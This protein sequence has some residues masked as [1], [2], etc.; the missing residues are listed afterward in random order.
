MG[1]ISLVFYFLVIIPSAI[2]HE[3]AHGWMADRLGDPTARLA[4]RLTIDPRVHIDP[5]GT[6]AMPLVLGLLSGGRFLFAYAKP[7]PFNPYNLRYHKWGPAMVGI[8]GPLANF[9]LALVFALLIRV[10]P[11][12]N[13]SQLLAVVVQANLV[14]MV[15]NL[16]P[17]PPLD[18][19]KILYA[20]LPDSM[21]HIK[22]FLDRYG[23]MLLMVFIFFLSN[24]ISPIINWLF[25][26]LLN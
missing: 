25:N 10:L 23:F 8:A 22:I 24:L 12:T 3:Y 19:S 7:V 2:I 9:M 1:I 4:G 16:V 14:L 13:F 18:G 5:I 6:I 26:L 21:Q 17:I 20:I 15:F 11:V